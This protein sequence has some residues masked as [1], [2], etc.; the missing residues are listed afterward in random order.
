MIGEELDSGDIITKDYLPININTK[1]ETCYKWMTKKTPE[2]FIEAIQK[3]SKNQKYIFEKQS[4]EPNDALRCYPRNPE[5]GKINWTKSNIEILRLINASGKPYSGAFCLYQNEPM[6][7]WDAELYHDNEK[8][9][10]IPGQIASID[11]DA[12]AAIVI[13]G[14]GKLLIKTISFG[15]FTGNPTEII[16]SIRKRLK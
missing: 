1:I 2:M 14:S 13:T 3:L 11:K 16:K 6:I 5:D 8:Y 10:A 15:T 9:C 4:K 7:I 12:G